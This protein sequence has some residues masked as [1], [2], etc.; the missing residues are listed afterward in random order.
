MGR[1]SLLLAAVLAG[2]LLPDLAAAATLPLGDAAFALRETRRNDTLWD[3]TRDLPA[4]AGVTQ[5]QVMMAVLRHNPAAF[6]RG[7]VFRLRRGVVLTVPSLAEIRAEP[8][9]LAAE[10][11]QRQEQAWRGGAGQDVALYPLSLAAPVTALPDAVPAYEPLRV[12]LPPAPVAAPAPAPAPVI[13]LP[14]TVPAFEPLRVS[15]PPAPVAP[16]AAAQ[17]PAPIAEPAPARP[18]AV[19]AEPPPPAVTATAV[20]LPDVAGLPWTWPAAAGLVLA[21]ALGL[22]GLVRRRGAAPTET[23]AAQAHVGDL[24]G[25]AANADPADPAELDLKLEL[26]R[27]Y[28]EV[29]REACARRILDGAFAGDSRPPPPVLHLMAG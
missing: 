27:A 12:S 24:I 1:K 3:L 11:Y 4:A 20:A 5:P 8:A 21:L 18:V 19:V 10:A 2:L 17:E 28:R 13:A 16:P 7:S 9:D 22:F 25:E 6:A 14:D 23:T 26:A 15:L 29:G